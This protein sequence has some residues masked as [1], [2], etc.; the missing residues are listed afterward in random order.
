VKHSFSLRMRTSMYQCGN[1]NIVTSVFVPA[2][3]RFRK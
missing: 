1:G 2:A 3:I